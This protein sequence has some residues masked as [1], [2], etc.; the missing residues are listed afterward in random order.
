MIIKIL[1]KITRALYVVGTVMIIFRR[2]LLRIR[3]ISEKSCTENKNLF[4]VKYIF[5]P[6]IFYRVRG[7]VHK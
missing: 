3:N 7:K 4:C 1:H 6:R 2:T 5:F